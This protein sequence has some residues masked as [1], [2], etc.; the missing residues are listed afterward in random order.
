MRFIDRLRKWLF[1]DEL[2]EAL[3]E[4]PKL[5]ASL[6]WIDDRRNELAESR[7]LCAEKNLTFLEIEEKIQQRL[8]VYEWVVIKHD[9]QS[10]HYWN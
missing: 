7:E 8:E 4:I 6:R 9:K 3:R 1:H 2:E 5:R 10:R